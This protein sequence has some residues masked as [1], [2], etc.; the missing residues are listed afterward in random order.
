MSAV[1]KMDALDAFCIVVRHFAISC[2]MIPVHSFQDLRIKIAKD[3]IE[4]HIGEKSA[5]FMLFL[6]PF[7]VMCICN[8]KRV[9]ARV[10]IVLCFTKIP[11]KGLRDP[12]RDLYVYR[13][14]ILIKFIVNAPS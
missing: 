12:F 11:L 13:V 14:I 9:N 6:S 10:V 2:D 7:P 8:E 5:I 1:P 4:I 3:G